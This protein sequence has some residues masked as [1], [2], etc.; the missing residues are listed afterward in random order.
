[1]DDIDRAKALAALEQ[2]EAEKA[3]RLQAK[4]DSGEVVSVQTTV[5]VG[6]DENIEEAK[7]R[8][9]ARHP[10]SDSDGRTVHHEFFFVV[11][12]VP[13]GPDFGQWEPSPQVQTASSEGPSHPSSEPAGGGGAVLSPPSQPAYIFVTTRP[14]TDDGDPGAI[15]EAYYTIEDGAVVLRDRDD[16]HITSRALLKDEDPA[17]VARALLREAEEPKDFHRPINYPKLGLA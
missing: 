17:A 6:P 2:L 10:V 3:R 5:V 12:G 4:I 9:L 8:A 16:K 11:T 15:A 1:M 14:A 13:R 7:A